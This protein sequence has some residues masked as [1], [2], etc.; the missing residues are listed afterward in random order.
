[1]KLKY[2]RRSD[3]RDRCGHCLRVFKHY[4]NKWKDERYIG[5]RFSKV[6]VCCRRIKVMHSANLKDMLQYK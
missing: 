5:Y 6:G 2:I 4:D 1:M 3:K